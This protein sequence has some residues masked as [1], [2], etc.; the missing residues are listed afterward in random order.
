MISIEVANSLLVES[1]PDHF[2]LTILKEIRGLWYL[3][4]ARV[5]DIVERVPYTEML[6]ELFAATLECPCGLFLRLEQ[7]FSKESMD[8]HL[9]AIDSPSWLGGCRL[10]YS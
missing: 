2:S 6:G 3:L 7:S 10:R 5:L 4:G 8:W 9:V 1:R